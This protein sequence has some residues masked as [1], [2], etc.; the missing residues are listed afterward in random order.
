M[1]SSQP[2]EDD[3]KQNSTTEKSFENLVVKL[4]EALSEA[5]KQKRYVHKR[6]SHAEIRRDS[7]GY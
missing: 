6:V 1:E 4:S 2:D 5:F 7:R 3:E